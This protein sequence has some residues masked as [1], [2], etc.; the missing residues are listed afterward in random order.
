MECHLIFSSCRTAVLGTYE[1]RMDTLLQG[2]KPESHRHRSQLSA[3]WPQLD[4]IVHP[5]R[6]GKTYGK[7]L[8]PEEHCRDTDWKPKG[9]KWRRHVVPVGYKGKSNGGYR[10]YH[11]VVC[12]WHDKVW[13][14]SKANVLFN[15]LLFLYP[16]ELS[17]HLL[18]LCLLRPYFSFFVSLS[19]PA[20]VSHSHSN[21][22]SR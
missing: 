1:S 4:T 9:I 15:H 18:N 22:T 13:I 2:T 6:W 19:D 8:G 16:A 5:G 12:Q 17:F 14:V 7:S 20:S 21:K 11:A 10:S 3:L